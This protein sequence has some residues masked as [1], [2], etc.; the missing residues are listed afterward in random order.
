[1]YALQNVLSIEDLHINREVLH[2]GDEVS[3]SFRITENAMVTLL[4]Y[5]SD[6]EV[7]RQLTDKEERPS[8]TIVVIWDG[9]DDSGMPV[10]FEAYIISVIADGTDGQKA[11]YDPTAISGGETLDIPVKEEKDEFGHYSISYSLPAP[12]RVNIMAG[13]HNG[14]MLKSILDWKPQPAGAHVQIWDGYDE[15]GK[16]DL[17]SNNNRTIYVTGFLLP[18]NTIIVKG[19]S[20]KYDS[21][22]VKEVRT[23]EHANTISHQSVKKN[24]LKRSGKRIS[25][26]YMVPGRLN[27]APRFKV[28]LRNDKTFDLAERESNDVS[29]IV[30]LSVEVAPESI[31]S[32]NESRYEI[33]VFVDNERFDEEEQ[34]YTP[35]S[36]T[37]DTN[38]FN[39]GEHWITINLSS[40]TGQI[41]SYSFKLNVRN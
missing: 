20:R 10:P 35:Y 37:I 40:L 3:I 27:V 1:M 6:Y 41:G 28:Y 33:V 31:D 5:N 11:V 36:Y 2:P 13:I 12:A 25:K 23:S 30:N 8:G 29:G 17:T 22:R 24:I 39:N 26:Q 4:I 19:K 14:P 18:E 15:T 38:K 9:M 32:F 34:A 21:N 7:V 16:I